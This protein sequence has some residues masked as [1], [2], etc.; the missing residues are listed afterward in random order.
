MKKIYFVQNP[1]HYYYYYT[2]IYYY[3]Y[4]YNTYI[5]VSKTIKEINNLN[6]IKNNEKIIKFYVNIKQFYYY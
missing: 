5:K 2:I 6:L 1:L 4:C 3:Y